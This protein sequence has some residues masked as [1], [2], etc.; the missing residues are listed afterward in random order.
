[1]FRI[2]HYLKKAGRSIC[3]VFVVILLSSC[4][5][6]K[7]TK[8]LAEQATAADDYE[9]TD[10]H[11]I[12]QALP[13]LMVIPSDNLLNEYGALSNKKYDNGRKYVFR[14]YQHYLQA[15]KDNQQILSVI[16]EA[17]L[18]MNYP[19]TDLEQGLK[20]LST[21]EAFDMADELEKDSKTL[22]LATIQPDIIL[23]LDYRNK[24]D[25][26]SHD[27]TNR[28]LSYTLR[29]I[30]AYTNK[31]V[32]SVN[33]SGI[34]GNEVVPLFKESLESKMSTFSQ[35]IIKYFSD[36]LYRGREVTLRVAVEKGANVHLTD[37][38]V[39]G[40]TYADWI[41]DYLD[42]HSVKGAYKLQRNTDDELYFVNVRIK[43]LNEDGTQYSVYKW[44]R[45]FCKEIKKNLGVKATNKAQGLG[46][47]L[48]TISGL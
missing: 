25:L 21:Q 13:S 17:F 47:I 45:E 8:S 6:G 16:Q 11:A 28:S 10:V 44:T 37:E 48:V 1:M 33:E 41:V 27:V 4:S 31:V 40:D 24:M 9:T 38:N 22:L 42:V 14:D 19:L 7:A 34:D 46:E 35:D 3:Y 12:Q 39:E 29:A 2:K 5:N 30:D 26:S 32:S 43:L 20:H 18:N 36:I 15:N 23:E